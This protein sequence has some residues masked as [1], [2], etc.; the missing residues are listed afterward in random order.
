M[1]ATKII[2]RP[3]QSRRYSRVRCFLRSLA[4]LLVFLACV[5]ATPD[6]CLGCLWSYETGIDGKPIERHSGA[7]YSNLVMLAHHHQDPNS[8][9]DRRDELKTRTDL[10]NFRHRNDYAVALV[11]LGELDQAIEILKSIETEHPGHYETA[12]NLG[13]AYELHGELAPALSWIKEG[14]RRNPHSHN[15]TEWIHAKILEAK[16]LIAENPAWLDKH[17]VLG[18]DFGDKL[19][20]SRPQGDIK[21]DAGNAKTLE[22]VR[23]AIAYQL[24]ERLVFVSSPDVTVADLLV[25]LGNILSL[26]DSV[27]EATPIYELALEYGPA[28]REIL[29]KRLDHFRGLMAANPSTGKNIHARFIRNLVMLLAGF[30]GGVTALVLCVVR[31]VRRRKP[32]PSRAP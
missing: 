30:I 9:K 14:I 23:Q 25:D 26:T 19:I 10:T 22:D 4:R 13:T 18:I 28:H 7:D 8:W 20:P 15:G 29:Q 1:S 24:N 2:R 27:E 31:T 17:T 6:E 12:A 21:D 16:C 3:C 11:H 5:P 32:K